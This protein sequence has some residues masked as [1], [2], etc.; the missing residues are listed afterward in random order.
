M[1][2]RLSYPESRTCWLCNAVKVVVRVV[3]GFEH[4]MCNNCDAGDPTRPAH[5]QKPPA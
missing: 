2:E 1:A 4:R 5:W 3:Q